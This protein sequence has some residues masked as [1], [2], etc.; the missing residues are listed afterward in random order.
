[1]L[2]LL[3]Y[4][5]GDFAA[6]MFDAMAAPC[7]HALAGR[8][9]VVFR[10]PQ[11]QAINNIDVTHALRRFALAQ[12]ALHQEQN[13][14]LRLRVQRAAHLDESALIAALQLLFGPTQGVTVTQHDALG[15]VVQYTRA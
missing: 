8:P 7:L 13:G 4:R 5:T 12:F 14:H 3:R 9:P 10:S 2:P 1:M 11:G 6:L 15:K